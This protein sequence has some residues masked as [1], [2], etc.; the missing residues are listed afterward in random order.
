M[1]NANDI[2]P[3]NPPTSTKRGLPIIG[4]LAGVAILIG[5]IWI[6]FSPAASN[7][8]EG[9]EAKKSR[10]ITPIR[11]KQGGES[12]KKQATKAA[13]KKKEIPKSLRKKRRTLNKA[14]PTE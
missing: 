3:S 5:A 14:K 13:M 1:A 12:L 4:I 6:S 9:P 7:E 8:A 11:G 10:K 2:E